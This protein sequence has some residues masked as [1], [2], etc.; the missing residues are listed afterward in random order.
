MTLILL[1]IGNLYAEELTI[2]P[3]KKPV[4][5]EIT[6]RQKIEQG[7]IRPKSKPIQKIEEKKISKNSIK[8]KPKPNKK[9]KKIKTKNYSN[10]CLRKI[11]A[12]TYTCHSVRRILENTIF[13]LCSVYL[14]KIQNCKC[15]YI[16]Q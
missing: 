11:K 8:P 16:K 13:L 9:E 5:D 10:Y 14:M 15:K 12:S 4:L 7:I 2:I 3:L 6:E 1:F